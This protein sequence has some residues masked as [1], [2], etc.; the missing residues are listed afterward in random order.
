MLSKKHMG[1]DRSYAEREVWHVKDLLALIYLSE[2]QVWELFIMYASTCVCLI[3][4]KVYMIAS[5]KRKEKNTEVKEGT[6]LAQAFP[7]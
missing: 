6:D 2:K 5:L 7:K 3:L 1:S 4:G